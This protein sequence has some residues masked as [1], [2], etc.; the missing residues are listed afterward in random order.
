M[1]VR[2]N[3]AGVVASQQGGIARRAAGPVVLR[4]AGPFNV[5]IPIAYGRPPLDDVCIG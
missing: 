2:P 3:G 1:D 4:L 5:A